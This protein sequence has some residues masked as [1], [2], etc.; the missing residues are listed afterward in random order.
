MTPKAFEVLLALV[1]R[2]GKIVSKNEL[3]QTVWPNTVV[4]E[5]GLT[6]NI[7]VLRKALG[8]KPDEHNYIVT[9]PGTGYRFV[10]PVER[11]DTPSGMAR[12][13][14]PVRRL[15]PLASVTA[16][17]LA[18]VGLIAWHF[19]PRSV[20]PVWRA[21]PLTSYPGFERHPALSPGGNQAAFAW[22]GEKQ[23]NFDIYV[24]TIGADA[25][26][27]LTTNPAEDV[28]P[29]WSPDGRTIGSLR[30]LA[31]NRNELLLTPAWGGTE[32]R[33]AETGGEFRTELPSLAWSP[34]GR[35]LV[36]SHREP[37]DL[38]NG[39]FLVSAQTGEK[40]R[41][42][43][44]PRGFVGDY[45]PAFSPDGRSLAFV[46]LS[47]W[48][49]GE[50]YLLPLSS[51]FSASGEPQ[52]LTIGG[53]WARWA[54]S[55]VW[56]RDGRHIV[57]GTDKGLQVIAV[58]GS[59]STEPV[60]FIEG[61]IIGLSLD[62]PLVYSRQVSDDNI[63][64]AEI[65][66]PAVPLGVPLRLIASTRPM[67]GLDTRR[68]ARRS[69]LYRI[70]LALGKSGLA[71]RR[72]ES[73][74]LTSFGDPRHGLVAG[75]PADR[76]SS[77]CDGQG[78]LFTIPSLVDRRCVSR[79][80]RPTIAFRFHGDG[81]WIY[82]RACARV[83]GKS[84]GCGRKAAGP[85][86]SPARKR[87]LPMESPD[88]K[89]LYYCHKLPEKGIWKVPAQGGDAVQVTGSYGPPLCAMTVT[90]DGLYYTAAPDSSNQYPIPFVSFSTGKS[91]PVVMSDSPFSYLGA[92]R[93]ARPPFSPLR[94]VRSVRQRSDGGRELRRTVGFENSF[95]V[96]GNSNFR[97][98]RTFNVIP[99]IRKLR[100]ASGTPHGATVKSSVGES[101]QQ[102][103]PR[104]V[105]NLSHFASL[106]LKI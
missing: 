93:F 36:V 69:S 44:A 40:R 2:H 14:P 87:R 80:I 27:R 63:W 19:W 30:R 98:S 34:D 105:A 100:N 10:A 18:A 82:F 50:V 8:E 20:P 106:K 51:D 59:R 56:T 89:T 86:R 72:V 99:T 13:P 61:G 94:S 54:R 11:A 3:I 52:R 77:A 60:P 43:A 21:V 71:G 46:R 29:S 17:L 9:V 7:S 81:R 5:I 90:A 55:P 48:S 6:R 96:T 38:A 25:P 103:D 62:R 104:I 91:R 4:E 73:R 67:N 84:G 64:R 65:G 31:A 101:R 35:W 47:G 49:V 79:P 75:Q 15:W 97:N 68:T 74:Q 76:L 23:D 88:G 39:L 26:L 42:T 41:L 70:G 22:D 58:S 95:P 12:K 85:F 53:G 92:E 32:R 83:D 24:K 102:R 66:P 45:T 78:D 28:S 1:E 16:V 33:L 57:Y 37:A